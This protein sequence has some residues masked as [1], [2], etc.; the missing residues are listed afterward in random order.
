MGLRQKLKD[1]IPQSVQHGF[2]M[3]VDSQDEIAAGFQGKYDKS[4]H[5]L[6]TLMHHDD[7][8]KNMVLRCA[9]VYVDSQDDAKT[10]V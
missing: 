5:A 10:V 6:I 4:M 9:K 3:Y 8:I 1:A 7:A 2:F